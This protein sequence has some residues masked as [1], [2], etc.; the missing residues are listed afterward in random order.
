MNISHCRPPGRTTRRVASALLVSL[1][2][3]SPAWA[4]AEICPARS[5]PELADL[6]RTRVGTFESVGRLEAR[7]QGVWEETAVREFYQR[8]RHGPAWLDRGKPSWCAQALALA[9]R[10]VDTAGLDRHTYH[11]GSIDILLAKADRLPDD[12]VDLDILLTDAFLTLAGHHQSG[13]VDPA[14][15]GIVWRASPPKEALVSLLDVALLS[16]NPGSAVSALQPN[17]EGYWLLLDA[18]ARLRRVEDAG[19]WGRVLE[20]P[21]L[22]Q[23]DTDARVPSLR[24]RL[25]ADAGLAL[26]ATSPHSWWFDKELEDAVRRFQRRHGLRPDGAVGRETLAAMNVSAAARIDQIELNL[27]R[28]RWLPADLGHRHV[29]VNVAAFRLE[30]WEGRRAVLDM[31]AVVGLP[32]RATPMLSGTITHMVLAPYWHMPERIAA[33]DKLPVIKTDPGY[34]TRQGMK[35]Y[36]RA[37]DEEVDP[38]AIDWASMTGE[39]LNERFRIRQDP[40]PL[41]ALGQVKFV[42]P[43]PASV[44]LHDT[45]TRSLFDRSVRALSSGCV[46][47]EKALDLAGLLLARDPEWPLKRI[48]AVAAGG[49]ETTVRLREPVPVH[50]L[51]WT[52]FVDD[53]RRLHFRPDIY[54]WDR[55]LYRALAVGPPTP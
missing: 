34:L 25:L 18:L 33:V 9:L 19:G 52:A 30:A 15:L 29:R 21:T 13:R 51:Y 20:G 27:E 3:T 49:R 48:R 43:N 45:P 40:G 55:N 4:V 50:L 41:N 35:V 46:R 28:W 38:A 1:L 54:G 5:D 47:V 42:F 23:G 10:R 7:G 17:H 37:T 32:S 44:F 16:G 53:E 8:R 6:L 2:L 12:L 39:E 26:D 22:H 36:S 14:A 31:K 11:S 24:R